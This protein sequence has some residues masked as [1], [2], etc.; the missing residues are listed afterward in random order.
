MHAP[1]ANPHIRLEGDGTAWIDNTN[2]KVVEV[3][4]DWLANSSSPEEMHFQYPHLSLAQIHSALAY[5][6][7]HRAELD[8]E[9][10][11]RVEAVESLRASTGAQ[12]TRKDLLARVAR[13]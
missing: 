5:Y 9:I 4:A 11:R 3:V 7:D 1:T 12:P 8:A 2:V 6:Y 10:A 13:R